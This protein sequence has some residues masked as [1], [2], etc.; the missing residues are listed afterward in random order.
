MCKSDIGT[1]K[2]FVGDGRIRGV[3]RVLSVLLEENTELLQKSRIVG[4]DYY[5]VDW[6]WHYKRAKENT[7][8]L[9]QGVLI[10]YLSPHVCFFFI[11]FSF[12]AFVLL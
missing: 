6:R 3:I 8:R 4:A 11:I 5:G 10:S 2:I 7:K 1:S 12:C 9:N